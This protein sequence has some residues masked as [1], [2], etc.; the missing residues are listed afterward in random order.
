MNYVEL[1]ESGTINCSFEEPY[2]GIYWYDS[3]YDIPVIFYEE[4]VKKGTGYTNGEYDIYP[5]GSLKINAVTLEHETQ[6]TVEYLSSTSD[7][8]VAFEVYVT[9]YVEP[10]PTFPL[11][12]GC[13]NV[14]HDICFAHIQNQHLLCSLHEVRPNISVSWI[15]RTPSGDIVIPSKE[16]VSPGNVWYTSHVTSLTTI[17]NSSLLQLL[18]CKVGR[19]SGLFEQDE[20]LI[21]VQHSDG[22]MSTIQPIKRR[23]ELHTKLELSCD[24][25][26]PIFIVWKKIKSNK[27]E[28]VLLWHAVSLGEH[29]SKIVNEDYLFRIPGNLQIKRIELEHEGLYV[30]LFGDGFSD[31][32]TKYQVDVYVNPEPNHLIIDGCNT[33]QYCVLKLRRS[34]NLTCSVKGIYP[35]IQLQLEPFY[36]AK[37]PSIKFTSSQLTSKRDGELFHV[38]LTSTYEV[39]DMALEKTTVICKAVGIN[40]TLFNLDTKLDVWILTEARN[41]CENVNQLQAMFLF[42]LAALIVIATT[43]VIKI[44]LGFLVKSYKGKRETA[45]TEFSLTEVRLKVGISM[46][47]YQT[48]SVFRKRIEKDKRNEE[49]WQCDFDIVSECKSVIADAECLQVVT[50]VLQKL[51]FENFVTK[52]SHQNILEGVFEACGVPNHRYDDVISYMEQNLAIPPEELKKK[53]AKVAKINSKKA[54]KLVTLLELKECGQLKS[55]FDNTQSVFPEKIQDGIVE[56]QKLFECCETFGIRHK[57]Q[58]DFR[59]ACALGFYTGVVFKTILTEASGGRYDGLFSRLAAKQVQISGVGFAFYFEEIFSNYKSKQDIRAKETELFITSDDE[60]NCI[61]EKIKLCKE[62]WDAGIKTD[63]S[64]FFNPEHSQS[65]PDEGIRF[66]AHI[67]QSEM[68]NGLVNLKDMSTRKEILIEA[69]KLTEYVRERRNISQH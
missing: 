12:N 7:F 40:A 60:A 45:E 4:S 37:I 56:L 69:S 36:E 39:T 24:K 31:G 68:S 35:E 26:L 38:S 47:R 62:A 33:N 50:D 32:L 22:N 64:Y 3:S 17:D 41:N 25:T 1:G 20:S 11:I 19:P 52:V 61:K 42:L 59:V 63:L 57:I 53:L 27:E 18:V 43:T 34:G 13:S 67:R 28:E 65:T 6:L 48:S 58:I 5:N 49:L 8:P 16:F 46:K 29:V 21:L 15:K 66:I 54:E 44:G 2:F 10:S 51:G 9:V 55:T 30:C 14:T 23:I